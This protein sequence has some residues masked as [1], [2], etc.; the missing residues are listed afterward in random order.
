MKIT[1]ETSGKDVELHFTF[2]SSDLDFCFDLEEILL[3]KRISK[4]HSKRVEKMWKLR[5]KRVEKMWKLHSKRV[6]NLHMYKN[7]NN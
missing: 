2:K 3:I 6:E 1:L 7:S 4:L 5:A